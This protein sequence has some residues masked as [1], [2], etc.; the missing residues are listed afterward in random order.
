[1]TP[2]L[3]LSND[4][5]VSIWRERTLGRP[6]IANQSFQSKG[7]PK[8]EHPLASI[9]WP[10]SVLSTQP[11]CEGIFPLRRHVSHFSPVGQ[12]GIESRTLCRRGLTEGG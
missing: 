7:A 2:R 12:R 10:T 8:A 4:K 11:T 1:M 3:S 5:P 9:A 6:E